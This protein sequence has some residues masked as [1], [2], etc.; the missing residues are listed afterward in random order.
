MTTAVTIRMYNLLSPGNC[1]LLRFVYGNQD[2]FIL[3][4]FGSYEEGNEARE[5]EIAENIYKT[6]GDKPLA[7]ILT[8]Q[9]REHSSGVLSTTTILKKLNITELWFSFP[10]NENGKDA[11]AIEAHM[12]ALWDKNR[13]LKEKARA[14]FGRVELV[15]KMLNAVDLLAEDDGQNTAIK[16]L[17]DWGRLKPKYLSPGETFHLPGVPEDV[18]RI[19]K[20]SADDFAEP[21]GKTS[22]SNGH[23]VE[24]RS[25][26]GKLTNLEA[27]SSLM[28][29]ALNIDSAGINQSESKDFPFNKKFSRPIRS[30]A[31]TVSREPSTKF[32]IDLYCNSDE[33][34]RIDYVWLNEMGRISSQMDKLRTANGHLLA[35]EL[36]EQ[37]KIL[38]FSSGASLRSLERPVDPNHKASNGKASNGIAVVKEDS[39]QAS[40]ILSRVVLYKADHYADSNEHPAEHSGLK[41]EQELV[42]MIPVYEQADNQMN[43]G[44]LSHDALKAYNRISQGR[45]LRSD[46]IYHTA[47][48]E[49]SFKFPFASTQVDFASAVKVEYDRVNEH[50]LFVE[51]TIQ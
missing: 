6:V 38:L 11:E 19:Y 2:A 26:I 37:H 14:R 44:K 18:V 42:I 35:F 10:K 40:N 4:D 12:K 5:L 39:L 9:H 27:S 16:S 13:S 17:A 46:T 1:F 20:L 33:W 29:D 34:R 32:V 45:I 30:G 23:S 43:T 51:Y 49:Q 7:L 21:S 50:H 47:K 31:D 8:G 28:F 22:S 25:L 41:N 24:D 15:D 48:N 3:I 36:A